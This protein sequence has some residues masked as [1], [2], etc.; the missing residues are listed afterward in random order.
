MILAALVATFLA[1]E[2]PPAPL[3]PEEYD[4]PFKGKLTILFLPPEDVHVRC[5]GT[6]QLLFGRLVQ[7]CAE[8]YSIMHCTIVLPLSGLTKENADRLY[9]HERGHCNGWP[10]DHPNAR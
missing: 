5:T 1:V 10:R 3:P 8:P 9:R 7:A 4:V 2:A 6:R